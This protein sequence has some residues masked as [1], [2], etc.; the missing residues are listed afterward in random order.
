MFWVLWG[1]KNSYKT[2]ATNAGRG[3]K[4][5]SYF[6]SDRHVWTSLWPVEMPYDFM[7]KKIA[8]TKFQLS[9]PFGSIII[10]YSCGGQKRISGWITSARRIV[11]GRVRRTRPCDERGLLQRRSNARSTGMEIRWKQHEPVTKRTIAD[12]VTKPIRRQRVLVVLRKRH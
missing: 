1:K 11:S 9:A 4:H 8:G 6:R 2:I 7:R 10:A 3:G 5:S 12:R